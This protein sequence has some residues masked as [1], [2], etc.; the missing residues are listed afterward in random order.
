MIKVCSES[1]TIPLKITFE[2][3]LRKGI[4]PEIWKKSNVVSIHEKEDKTLMKDYRL[5]SLLPIY[6]KIF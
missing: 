6:V 5:I 1:V 3:S 2:E 4:F